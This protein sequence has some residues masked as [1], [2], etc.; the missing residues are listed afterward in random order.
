MEMALRGIGDG[1]SWCDP[2]DP[3]WCVICGNC[4]ATSASGTVTGSN[5]LPM[6]ATV[7]PP[8]IDTNPQSPT[9]G[10]A[11]INGVAV[12][13]PAQAQTLV[14]AQIAANAQANAAAVQ[15]AITSQANAAAVTASCNWFQVFNSTNADCEFSVGAP[16]TILVMFAAFLLVFALKKG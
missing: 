2:T 11:I 16:G 7:Q 9:Y 1:S 15:T 6:P 10:Q 14:N 3:F 8:A 4:L 5:P 12:G 13:T